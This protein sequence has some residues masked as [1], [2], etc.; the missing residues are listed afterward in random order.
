MPPEPF[1][2]ATRPM[3][4]LSDIH[5]NLPALEAVLVELG[6]RDVKD[7]FV[8]GDLVFGGEHPLEVWL[9]LQQ[10]GARCT[11]G[12]SD[13]A[14]VALDLTSFTPQTDRE[15]ERAKRFLQTRTALGDLVLER[16]RRLPERLRLP[17]LDGGELMMVHG[18]PADPSEEIAHDIDDEELRARIADDPAD[19]VV[20]GATHVP[21]DRVYEDI[22]IINVGS[23]GDAPEGKNAH[24]TVI[25]PRID[26]VEID[27]SWVS[28]HS[29]GA[30]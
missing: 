26:G 20:C 16:L 28:Y 15:R 17:L 4:F 5:G 23:V 25:T 7:V 11:R 6:R 2:P 14:L 19:I 10:I 18:S 1:A 29:G 13:T 8:A 12:L 30:R 21:F 24:Y 3:A 27:Q 22:R 9:R